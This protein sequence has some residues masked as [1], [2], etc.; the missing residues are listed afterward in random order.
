MKTLKEKIEV[1]QAA[2][3]GKQIQGNYG[4]GYGDLSQPENREDIIFNWRDCDYR[5]KPKPLE[6]WVNVYET[7]GVAYN[8]ES[9]AL[10]SID[11]TCLK[12]IKVIEVTE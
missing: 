9:K 12:T 3:D 11:S 10:S 4:A 7:N 6:F 2:L 8:S 1:M 5:I